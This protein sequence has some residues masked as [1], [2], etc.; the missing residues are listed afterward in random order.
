MNPTIFQSL[1]WQKQQQKYM[2]K[3][4]E[5]DSTLRK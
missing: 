2:Q 4:K 3:Q 1:K 5:R